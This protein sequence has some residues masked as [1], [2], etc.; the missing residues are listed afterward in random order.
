MAPHLIKLL[1]NALCGIGSMP[2]PSVN[3]FNFDATHLCLAYVE[4]IQ[5]R[6]AF[7]IFKDCRDNE[8]GMLEQHRQ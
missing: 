6:A 1:A 3:Y 4:P 5:A 2:V 7:A 8:N